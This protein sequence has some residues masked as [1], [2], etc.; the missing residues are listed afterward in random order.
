M[1]KSGGT[2]LYKEARLNVEPAY[3]GSTVSI[4][5]PATSTSSFS[6]PTSAKHSVCHET[7]IDQDD[8][9]FTKRHLA[10]DGCMYFRSRDAYPRSFLWRVLDDRRTLE[11]QATDLDH[12]TTNQ[13]EANLTL[14]LHFTSPIR[15]FCIAFADS[16]NALTVF[17]ITNANELY[18]ITLHATFFAKPASSEQID[19]WCKRSSPTLL[20]NNNPYRLVAVSSNELLASLDNGAIVRLTRTG[21]DA[22][23]WTEAVYQQNSWSLRGMLP[24][25]GQQTV[26]FDGADI[27]VSSVAAMALSPESKHIISV[28]LD[29]RL[30]IYNVAS[31]KLSCQQDLLHKAGPQDLTQPYT[32]GP[33][34]P[35]LLQVIDVPG[36]KGAAYYLVTYSPKEHQ[37]KFWGV[38]DADDDTN[39]IFDVQNEVDFVPP[40]DELMNA[41]VWT[42]E[43]FFMI[44]GAAGWRGTELWIRARSGP[45]SGVYSLRFDLHDDD[46]DNLGS[47]WKT[48]WVAVDSG[49]LTVEALRKNTTNPG[50]QDYDTSDLYELDSK[51]QWLEFLF[52]PHR[53]TIATLETALLFFRKGLERNRST[54]PLRGSL[55][56]RLCA[57]VSAF[58]TNA[59]DGKIEP[60]NYERAISEQWQAYYGLVKDLHKRRGESL[61]LAYDYTTDMPW[62][63]L[64][65]YLSAIRKCN[66]SEIITL[67]PAALSNT[68]PLSEP[69]AEVIQSRE[70]RAVANLL[71]AAAGCRRRVPS[72]R[73]ELPRQVKMDLL[74][75]RS[76][77]VID[78]MELMEAEC[79]LYQLLTDDDLVSLVEELGMDYKALTTDLFLDAL[80]T[81]DVE[82]RGNHIR[83]KQI[84]RYGLNAL[85]TIV[86][87]DLAANYEHLLDLLFLILFLQYEEETSDD[88]DASV[89]FVELLDRFKNNMVLT[90]LATTVW[91]HQNSTGES[92]KE[93]LGLLGEKYHTTRLPMLQTVLEGMYGEAAFSSLIPT[94]LKSGLLTYWSRAWISLVFKA[95][96]NYQ[97]MVEG[98]M[99]KL[100]YQKEYNLAKDFAKFLPEST[101]ATYLKGRLHVAMGENALASVCFQK[102]AYTC[103]K[104]IICNSVGVMS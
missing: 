75:N 53:F 41:T 29:H 104:F 8:E 19:S 3:P 48:E 35:T 22:V 13:Y 26:R 72:L 60:E 16:P 99:G 5:L 54:R 70:Q 42:M 69:L 51:E 2:C 52:Y 28:C 76:V 85:H 9:A 78:R 59:Q 84:A 25:K 80:K 96:E 82:K 6:S 39:G 4:T 93:L 36:P 56:D 46:R 32:I 7:Y 18:T 81:L 71:N 50:E 15:P 67:N 86:Q 90:W 23:D 34:Q 97:T 30:R 12:D 66:D 45:S 57:T 79:D 17:A 94:G 40:V 87:E 10:S 24:W 44:P 43:E 11:I 91:S 100:L 1:T 102:I 27:A 47:V 62:L 14:L 74:Q 83:R 98:T 64:S 73:Q 63:V 88:F 92:S 101:W 31:G 37:F 58:A 55:K 95:T 61:S 49:P 33:S 89:V 65:D 77:T 38:R 21:R 68:V 20:Q 103:G